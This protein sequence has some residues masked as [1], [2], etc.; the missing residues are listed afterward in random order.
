[1]HESPTTKRAVCRLLNDGL[2]SG[3][4]FI[5]KPWRFFKMRDVLGVRIAYYGL[6]QHEKGRTY[7]IFSV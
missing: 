1:M 6:Q 4:N 7:V 3:F 5:A 2:P